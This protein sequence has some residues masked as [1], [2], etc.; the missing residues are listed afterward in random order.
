MITV[1]EEFLRSDKVRRAVKSVGPAAV[2]VWLALKAYASEHL[3]DGFIP[4]EDVDAVDAHV[5]VSEAS[6]GDVEGLRA[7]SYDGD[8]GDR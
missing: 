2:L 7:R 6:I 5:D 4:D 8:G 3:T 1:K